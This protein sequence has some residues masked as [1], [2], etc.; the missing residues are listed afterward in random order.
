[1]AMPG[2][3]FKHERRAVPAVAVDNTTDIV[4]VANVTQTKPVQQLW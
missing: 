4:R 3:T 2:S 1:M